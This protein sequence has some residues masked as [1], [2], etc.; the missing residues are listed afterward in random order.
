MDYW[1][2]CAGSGGRGPK[3]LLAVVTTGTGG[4]NFTFSLEVVVEEPLKGAE[5]A[6][7]ILLK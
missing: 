1:Y 4:G 7:Q 5:I 2:S 6:S 3:V